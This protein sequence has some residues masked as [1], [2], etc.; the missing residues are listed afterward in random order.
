MFK[1]D[2]ILERKFSR[3]DFLK[4]STSIAFL[5]GL[6]EAHAPKIANALEELSALKQ[7]VVW[8][9]G[10]SCSGCTVSFANS[11]YPSVSEFILDTISIKYHETLMAASGDVAE[12][13]LEEVLGKFKGK[14]IMVLEGAIPTKQDGIY[15]KVA[16]EPFLDKVKKVASG[17]AYKVAIGTCASFGGIPASG[18][19]PTGCKG[20]KE[21]VGGTVI[22]VPGCPA[23]PDWLVGTLV[24]VLMF[25]KI[26]PLDENG[27]PEMFY[28]KLIHDNCPRRGAY[29]RGQFIKYFGQEFQEIEGCMGAK[30]CRGP[31]TSADCPHRLWN[32]GVSFCI[33]ASAPCAGCVEPSFP[34]MSLYQPVPEVSRAVEQDKAGVSKENIDTLIASAGGAIAGAAAAA[35]VFAGPGRKYLFYKDDKKPIQD[36]EVK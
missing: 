18:P 23:H 14:Y 3:R 28:G 5:L 2:R 8:L 6:P 35:G 19:N 22:N 10:A 1:L 15:C 11:T 31:V 26:P 4:Y 20:L 25:N 16:G 17:A 13:G 9:N 21:V 36:E 12:R 24:N 34:Q 33:S 30:G 27:R 32:G 7:P 29:D